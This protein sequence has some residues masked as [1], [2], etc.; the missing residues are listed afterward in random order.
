MYKKNYRIYIYYNDLLICKFDTEN[1][2]WNWIYE[3]FGKQVVI[4]GFDLGFS[5]HQILDVAEK[6]CKAIHKKK[7]H[8]YKIKRSDIQLFLANYF[9][10]HKLNRIPEGEF[11]YL[12]HKKRIKK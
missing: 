5:I 3:N 6:Y 1:Q 2:D 4:S 11:L 7:D 9:L 10:L 12:K 8:S